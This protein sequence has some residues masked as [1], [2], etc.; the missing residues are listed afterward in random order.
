MKRRYIVLILIVLSW[1]VLYFVNDTVQAF[2]D[3]I[4]QSQDAGWVAFFGLLLGALIP[5]RK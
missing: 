4:I 2:T 1:T 3:R 5:K